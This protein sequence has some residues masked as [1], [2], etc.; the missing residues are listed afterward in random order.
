MTYKV[1]DIS[2]H[3]GRID[4]NRVKND[5]VQAVLIRAGYGF[6][7]KDPLLETYVKGCEKVGLPYGLYCYS[8]ATNLVQARMEVRG[9]LNCIKSYRPELPIVI[10]TEDA[11]GWRKRNGNP[12]F[13]LL[14]DMLLYELKEIEKAGYYAMYYSSK[15]W[16]DN[17][18]KCRPALKKYDLWLAHWG[19]NSPS[20]PCGIW[21]YSSK[22]KV[23]GIRT[24]VDM[25]IA[26]R[27][28]PAIMR[29]KGLNGFKKIEKPANAR[30]LICY[31]N[32]GDLANAAALLNALAPFADV[33]LKHGKPE[34]GENRT[35]I[36]IGGAEI[37]GADVKITGKDRTAVLASI[38]DFVDKVRR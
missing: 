38:G 31:I 35:V 32:D 2:K 3:N 4:F 19:I 30:Y 15:W 37:E 22:G 24:N 8:Y 36:Q 18:L 6:F 13:T 17:L 33:E 5:G 9:F 26:Y 11:D 12:S 14:A 1:I 34:S 20:M 7:N 25:N 29:E 10:D 23:K 21:Q 16:V 27:N 28:Y